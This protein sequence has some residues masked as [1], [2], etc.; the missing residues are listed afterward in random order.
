MTHPVPPPPVV[1]KGHNFFVVVGPYRTTDPSCVQTQISPLCQL[2]P[3]WV[4]TF[5]HMCYLNSGLA[6]HTPLLF[7]YCWYII[8]C[9]SPCL[10]PPTCS[11]YS[12]Q[13]LSQLICSPDC[14]L[15]WCLWPSHCSHLSTQSHG[16][17]HVRESWMWKL[18]IL[19]RYCINILL[20]RYSW[21]EGTV[22]Y[23]RLLLAP[24]GGWWP[25]ATWR[26]LR[27]LLIPPPPTR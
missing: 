21:L 23:G 11:H 3:S 24:A 20:L 15:S 25:S 12:Q 6:P 27:A 7:Q 16:L 10:A 2:L 9:P 26:A 4:L 5:S 14:V 19:S 22:A 8:C 13:P 17:L 1:I 18:T